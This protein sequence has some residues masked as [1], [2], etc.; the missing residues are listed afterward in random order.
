MGNRINKTGRFSYPARSGCSRFLNWKE[1]KFKTESERSVIFRSLVA[2]VKLQSELDVS[3]EAKAVKL[4][5]SLAPQFEGQADAFLTSLGRT[6]DESLK[7]FIQSIVVLLST[8]NQTITTAAMGM[9]VSLI[10][11]CS[12]KIHLTLVTADL[13]PQLI[14]NLNLQSLP[15][16]ETIEIHIY[17]MKTIN[18]TV[19][20]ATPYYLR[21][22]GIKD[23]NEQQATPRNIFIL[24][25]D[26]GICAS[27]AVSLDVR[28][29]LLLAT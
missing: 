29:T 9:L 26:D 27:Y 12:S 16:A 8:P 21:Q 14:N 6:T 3:L 2:T 15:F 23:G 20:L 10:W 25:T 24:S 4:L 18:W 22:L 5:K 7:I 13:L 17:L 1:N 19:W 28:H 11:N